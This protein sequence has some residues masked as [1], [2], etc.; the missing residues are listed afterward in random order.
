M[1]GLIAFNWCAHAILNAASQVTGQ[2][3]PNCDDTFVNKI[4]K[5]SDG[6]SAFQIQLFNFSDPFISLRD[7]I[8]YGLETF[9]SPLCS[10]C[11]NGYSFK[12]WNLGKPNRKQIQAVMQSMNIS[13]FN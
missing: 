13:A 8:Q 6:D 4:G 12:P 1:Q 7:R 9:A 2:S 10:T 3:P 5:G 11:I